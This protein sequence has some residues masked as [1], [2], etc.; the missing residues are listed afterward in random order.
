MAYF[1]K[2]NNTEYEKWLEAYELRTDEDSLTFDNYP[3]AS[4]EQLKSLKDIAI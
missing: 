2:F 3:M 1:V 4:T